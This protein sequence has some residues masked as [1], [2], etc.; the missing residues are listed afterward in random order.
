MADAIIR[1]EFI[2]GVQEV[3][4]T[5]LTNGSEKTDGVFFYALNENNS[6]NTYGES[7][8]KHY[9]QPVLLVCKAQ[10]NPT[11]GDEDVEEIKN[12][13]TFTVPVKSFTENGL[14]VTHIALE[15]MRRGMVKFHDVWYKIDNI[16]PTVFVEDIFL[17]YRFDCT[18]EKVFD[19]EAIIIDEDQEEDVSDSGDDP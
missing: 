3:Y 8:Y 18:E 9:N 12:I 7:R 11:H 17:L 1:Q 10:L 6:T 16:T 14:E 2:D 13:A 4:T 19:E 5:L 15:S